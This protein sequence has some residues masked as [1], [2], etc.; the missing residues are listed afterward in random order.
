MNNIKMAGTILLAVWLII[1]G[2]SPFLKIQIPQFNII[3]PLLAVAAGIAILITTEK[4]SGTIGLSL[5]GIYLLAKG[6]LPF[7]KFKIPG[8]TIAVSLIAIVCGIFLIIRR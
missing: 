3:L 1:T 7:I 5:L 4:P 6:L 2:L 8:S